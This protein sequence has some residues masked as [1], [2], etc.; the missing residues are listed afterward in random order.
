[1]YCLDY[2]VW[3]VFW[4]TFM[5]FI[6]VGEIGCMNIPK[7]HWM[8]IVV[9]LVKQIWFF[10]F[11]IMLPVGVVLC[12]LGQYRVFPPLATIIIARRHGMI[13]TWRC[14]HSTG[15]LSIYPTGRGGAHQELG[16]VYPQWWFHGPNH[17]KYD[18]WGCSP[19]NLWVAPSWWGCPAEK[20]Q[21]LPK[22]GELWCYHL[23]S[24]SY[25]RNAAW[26]MEVRCFTKC[27]FRAHPWGRCRGYSR[28]DLAQLWKA[29]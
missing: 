12:M 19:A 16:V 21:G 8:A 2:F 18:L 13:A 7:C 29:P 17:P 9:Y 20:N 26:Q 25:P 27:R 4:K 1:M 24:G 23:G 28:G 11:C 6:A 5:T 15:I 10:L 14:R 3:C 22:H